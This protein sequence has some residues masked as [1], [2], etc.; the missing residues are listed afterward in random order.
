MIDHGLNKGSLCL[1]QPESKYRACLDHLK[2]VDLTMINL[3]LRKDYFFFYNKIA[4]MEK[5]QGVEPTEVKHFDNIEDD[6][7]DDELNDVDFEKPSQAVAR[8]ENEAR[9]KAYEEYVRQYPERGRGG[10]G[11]R[12]QRGRGCGR[13]GRGQAVRGGRGDGVRGGRGGRGDC[14]A[15]RG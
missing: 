2:Q 3:L 6:E 4:E 5:K 9:Q 10:R 1:K 11:G 14:D 7:S 15:V 8:E 13:G 12:G